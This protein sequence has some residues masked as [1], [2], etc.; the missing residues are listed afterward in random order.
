MRVPSCDCIRKAL[1]QY[2]EIHGIN[3]TAEVYYVEKNSDKGYEEKS[4]FL[5][6]RYCPQCGE[7]YKEDLT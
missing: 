7:P 6:S 5:P 1:N 3:I 4:V 2:H